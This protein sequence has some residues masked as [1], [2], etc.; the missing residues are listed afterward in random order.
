MNLISRFKQIAFSRRVLYVM[1]GIIV[2]L[3]AAF[4]LVGFNMAY[5]GNPAYNAPML[6]DVI[7]ALMALMLIAALGVAA[8][9]IIRHRRMIAGRTGDTN[10]VPRRKIAISVAVITIL[11][12]IVTFVF[13]SSAPII[14]NGTQYD[15]TLW[16][17]SADMFIITSLLL[18][19][20]S[21]II[22]ILSSTKFFQRQK[23][24]GNDKKD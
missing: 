4:Y 16:L 14:I 20:I 23:T 13:G 15:D 6:T 2:L 11:A 8:W 19:M 18:I 21:V 22:L 3:F 24:A 9:T 1:I 5:E 17:K 10:G 12:V 7:L